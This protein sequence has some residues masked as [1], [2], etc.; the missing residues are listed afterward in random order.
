MINQI[1]LVAGTERVAAAATTA[2]LIIPSSNRH[3]EEEEIIICLR[4]GVELRR[5]RYLSVVPAA[6]CERSSMRSIYESV[7]RTKW[8]S[9]LDTKLSEK[10]IILYYL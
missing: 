3:Q 9:E 10:V 1:F 6:H 5:R 8:N 4:Q 7:F 2:Q